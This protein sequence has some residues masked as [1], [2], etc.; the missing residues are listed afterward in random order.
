MD[1]TGQ[2]YNVEYDGEGITIVEYAD[3]V[4]VSHF[5]SYDPDGE[6]LWLIGVGQRNGNQVEM[7]ATEP[8]GGKIGDPAALSH[9]HEDEW[10]TITLTETD[11]GVLNIRFTT[12]AGDT[13]SYDLQPLYVPELTPTPEPE[14]PKPPDQVELARTRPSPTVRLTAPFSDW[15]RNP[16]IHEH[17]ITALTTSLRLTFSASG[18]HNPRFV[19]VRRSE[20]LAPGESVY[21]GYYL[22]PGAEWDE[23]GSNDVVVYRVSAEGLGA[24]LT[25]AVYVDTP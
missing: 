23:T 7:V 18:P 10:G 1:F 14:E 13:W 3:S 12:S 22:D 16:T 15:M 19:G 11:E 6:Q 17:R 20:T 4:V 24:I 8:F 21:F 5:F 2:W 25:L 9:V